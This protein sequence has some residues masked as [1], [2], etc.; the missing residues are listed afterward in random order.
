MSESSPPAPAQAQEPRANA[1]GKPDLDALRDKRRERVASDAARAARMGRLSARERIRT[2]VDEGSFKETLEWI[3]PWPTDDRNISGEIDEGDGMITGHATSNGR[4]IVIIA[5]DPTCRRG[6]IGRAGAEKAIAALGAAVARGCPVVVLSDSDG[7][8]V[9]EG[10]D[11]VLGNASLL[12]HFASASGRVPL[13]WATLGLAGGAAGYAAALCDVVIAIERRSFTFITGPQVIAA[14]TREETNLEEIGGTAVHATKTGMLASVFPEEPEAIGWLKKLLG[15]LPDAA[16]ELP[17]EAP[18]AAPKV[19]GSIAS[20]LPESARRPYDVRKI[21]DHVVDGDSFLELGGAHAKNIVTG[22][23]RI[24]G[25]S[26]GIVASQPMHL[27]GVL[28]IAAS[29]KS[30]RF[31]RFCAAFNLPIVTFVDCPG[32]LP[33]VKQEQG[34]LL[35]HG[36][37]LISAYEEASRFVPRIA[38][39]LRRSCGA[40][41]VL[42]HGSDVVLALPTAQVQAMGVDGLMAVAW[43]SHLGDMDAEARE[44]ERQLLASMHDEPLAAARVGMVHRLVEPDRLR[45]ELLA[46]V[47][48][49]RAPVLAPR[50]GRKLSNIPL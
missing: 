3:R 44:R 8:R 20:I 35:L 14:V 36:A 9:H 19:T 41:S 31:I 45:E 48:A 46:E 30:A 21:M 33:G 15:Y 40:A 12:G 39:I 11:G 7:A 43:G 34:G 22:F 17:P 18:A 1:E 50:G 2:L 27:G 4:R 10:A 25:R 42:N 6:S 49:A 23:G 47:L 37:K 24:G 28:D 13:L 26:V 5:H 38:F 16:W 29:V 32:F